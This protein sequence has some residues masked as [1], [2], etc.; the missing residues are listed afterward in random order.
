MDGPKQ[1]IPSEVWSGNLA[2]KAKFDAAIWF[3]R[4]ASEEIGRLA[5]CGWIG[6]G[7]DSPLVRFFVPIDEE[8]AIVVSYGRQKQTNVVFSVDEY[9]AM[10]WLREHRPHLVPILLALPRAT[11]APAQPQERVFGPRVPAYA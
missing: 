3:R 7:D 8:V 11:R 5:A 1:Q 2:I 4:A 10:S 9:A 6:K